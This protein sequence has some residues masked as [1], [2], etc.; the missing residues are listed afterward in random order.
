[1]TSTLEDIGTNLFLLKVDGLGTISLSKQFVEPWY[2]KKFLS[3]EMA[4]NL[5][6]I[7]LIKLKLVL[8]FQIGLY[9]AYVFL[10]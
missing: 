10:S 1:M 5:K 2:G 8:L 9:W 7:L 4:S 6:T 3:L